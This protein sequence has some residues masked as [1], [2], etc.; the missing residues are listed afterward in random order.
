MAPPVPPY[1][2]LLS[3][4]WTPIVAVTAAWQG[5]INAQ[6]AVSAH[7]ASIVPD[8]PRILIQ[9][10]KRNLTHDMVAAS[11]AFALHLVH[12][13][14]L[15]LVHELGFVSGRT[16]DKLEN[17]PYRLGETGSPILEDCL[18]H[19]ECRVV[20]AM[21]GGDMTCFLGDVVGGALRQAPPGAEMRPLWWWE[22][23]Q[24]M[25]QAWQD[26]WDA[27]MVEELAFSAPLFDAIDRG[28]WRPEVNTD[29]D[30]DR[31]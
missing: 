4:L 16:V 17:I 5:R 21:D 29:G 22:M 25:P 10:Y 15:D 1:Q 9:L 23:R 14:Q 13:D 19:V 28:T 30:A 2:P 3:R 24:R 12:E 27:K 6:I 8:R 11:G 7:G 31:R 18:G 20:N 26:E